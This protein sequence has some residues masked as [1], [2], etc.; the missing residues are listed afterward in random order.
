MLEQALADSLKSVIPS[1]VNVLL[2]SGLNVSVD[3]DES[4]KKDALLSW[5]FE[6]S[7]TERVFAAA[8]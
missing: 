8:T 3:L 7:F 6:S 5:M 2:S 4:Y 1:M